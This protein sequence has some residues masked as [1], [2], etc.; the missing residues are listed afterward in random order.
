MSGEGGTKLERS[1][2]L[3]DCHIHYGKM[4]EINQELTD[5]HDFKAQHNIDKL[6]LI[7][8]NDVP[9]SDMYGLYWLYKGLDVAPLTDKMIGYKFHGTYEQKPVIHPNYEIYLRYLDRHDALL[10]VHCGRYKEGHW[11]S[12]TSYLHALSAAIKYPNTKIIMAHMGGTDTTVC[13]KAIDAS[14]DYDNIYFDTSGI[15][16]PYIIEY[17]VKQIPSTRIMFGSD[18]P[19]CSFNAMYWTVM[20]AQISDEDKRNIFSESFNQLIRNPT[21]AYL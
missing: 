6:L 19:W 8:I 21:L 16:T 15:T 4:P 20:D 1:L 14:R 18:A 11:T 7:G 5:V 17:A 12:N 13:K 10:M 2:E 9:W 3:C